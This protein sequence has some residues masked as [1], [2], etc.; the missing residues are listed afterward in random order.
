MIWRY[1]HFRKHPTS[2]NAE[3]IDLNLVKQYPH[4]ELTKSSLK[5]SQESIPSKLNSK[6][7]LKIHEKESVARRN[8]LLGPHFL[9]AFADRNQGEGQWHQAEK[10]KVFKFGV[11]QTSLCEKFF[12]D[13]FTCKPRNKPTKSIKHLLIGPSS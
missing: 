4:P 10:K 2:K 6:S 3:I 13:L 8:Y 12:Q 7:P 9:G 5:C 1:H 11:Q